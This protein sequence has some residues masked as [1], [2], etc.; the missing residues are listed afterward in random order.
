MIPPG[1][2]NDTLDGPCG[3]VLLVVSVAV[4]TLT[5]SAAAPCKHSLPATSRLAA[6][7]PQLAALRC[8]HKRGFLS[9]LPVQSV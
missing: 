7:T 9:P 1:R 2:K 3:P 5:I 8:S 4:W 6:L